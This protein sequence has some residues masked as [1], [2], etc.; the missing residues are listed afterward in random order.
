MIPSAGDLTYFIEVASTLNVSK[1]AERLGISQPTL[2]IAIQRLE[3]AIDMPLFIRS[4]QGVTLTQ[5]GKQLLLHT[6]H[7][8]QGWETIRTRALASVHEIRG[9]YTFGCHPSVALYALGSFIPKLLEENL[10][11]EIKLVHDLSRNITESIIQ[12]EI[13]IGLV[14][15]PIKHP[16]LIIRKLCDDEVTLWVGNGNKKIQDPYSGAAVLICDPSLIQTQ[17][18]LKKLKKSQIHYRRIIPSS[19][20]EI[21]T[22]LVVDGAGIGII[23]GRVA[24][25]KSTTQIQKIPQAPSF[26]DEICL[27]YRVENRSIRSIQT[28]ADRVIS[29]F[30]LS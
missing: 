27:I 22:Q 14:V 6:R 11:L 30:K 26:H 12:L 29:S 25:F 21:I 24:T 15:N 9:S 3:R 23:P 13:D 4:K 20:L 7:L 5:P 2:T 16:D 18:L 8:L 19:N 10:E 28:I 1:A 17:E